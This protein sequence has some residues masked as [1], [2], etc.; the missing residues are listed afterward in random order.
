MSATYVRQGS[1]L[2]GVFLIT[3]LEVY[4]AREVLENFQ[5]QGIG[6]PNNEFPYG[7]SFDLLLNHGEVRVVDSE[8]CLIV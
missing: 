7:F 8:V 3:L 4:C 1:V 6:C 5:E 2:F